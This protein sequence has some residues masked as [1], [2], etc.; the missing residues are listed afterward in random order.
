[1][2]SRRK[3]LLVAQAIAAFFSRQ[4]AATQGT[5]GAIEAMKN[6]REQQRIV[7]SY[8]RDF[9]YGRDR[10]RTHRK[11]NSRDTE[12]RRRKAQAEQRALLRERS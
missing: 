1:M 5:V 12:R 9:G 4:D 2:A 8:G 11:S 3:G 7:A 10:S 6:L